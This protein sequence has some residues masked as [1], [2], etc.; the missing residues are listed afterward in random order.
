LRHNVAKF[1]VSVV[2]RSTS[3]RSGDRLNQLLEF[4]VAYDRITYDYVFNVRSIADMSQLNL[5]L[6]NNKKKCRPERTTE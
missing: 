2:I 1:S 3:N 6:G 4:N 5:S